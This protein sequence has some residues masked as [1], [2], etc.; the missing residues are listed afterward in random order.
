MSSMNLHSLRL[1]LDK[2]EYPFSQDYG[3]SN[4]LA[5]VIEKT[6]SRFSSKDDVRG[7]L[8]LVSWHTLVSWVCSIVDGG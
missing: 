5:A 3:E 2:A 7:F 1:P 6:A 4:G 8:A